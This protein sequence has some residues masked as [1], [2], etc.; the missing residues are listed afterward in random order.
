MC[1]NLLKA[2]SGTPFPRTEADPATIDRLR[3][4]DA[5]GY[6]KVLIPAARVDCDNCMRQDAATVLEIAPSG[7]KA[8]A[9]NAAEPEPPLAVHRPTVSKSASAALDLAQLA[10]WFSGTRPRPGG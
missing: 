6:I 7:W 4:L 2:I 1:M 5:A 3:V 10:A 8:L 9:A